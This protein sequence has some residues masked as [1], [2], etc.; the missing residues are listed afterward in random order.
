MNAQR[1]V[2]HLLNETAKRGDVL[3]VVARPCTVRS[4][5]DG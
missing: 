1:S 3:G 4:A 2:D 5:I